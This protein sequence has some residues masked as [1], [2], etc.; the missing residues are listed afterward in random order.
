MPGLSLRRLPGVLLPH[1]HWDECYTVTFCLWFITLKLWS[2]WGCSGAIAW[3]YVWYK[4]CVCMCIC[5]S[6]AM[7]MCDIYIYMWVCFFSYCSDQVTE[8]KNIRKKHLFELMKYVHSLLWMGRQGGGSTCWWF[9]SGMI[10]VGAPGCLFCFCLASVHSVQRSRPWDG[11]IPVQSRSATNV[12][13]ATHKGLLQNTLGIVVFF[14]LMN[15]MMMINHNYKHTHI[16][17]V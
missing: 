2:T 5:V 12:L 4:S 15:L 1:V 13:P 6:W 16:L 14:N 11:F 3:R 8:I 9:M 17:Y 7:Y 10:M